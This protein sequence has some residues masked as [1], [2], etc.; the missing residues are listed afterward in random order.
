[1]AR[2]RLSLGLALLQLWFLAVVSEERYIEDTDRFPGWKGEL[3]GHNP[4][5]PK[6]LSQEKTGMT[7]GYGENGV[8]L[9]RGEVIPV[10]W[11][12]R[13]FLF[14]NFLNDTEC[15]HI[16]GKAKPQ[17]TKS[18]VVDNDTGKSVDSTVR[19]STGT[20]FGRGQDEII[21]AVEKRVSLVSHL[22]VENGEGMQVLHYKDGQ[23][24]EPH[25][26]FF[27]DKYNANPTNGGQRA[28][29]V[30]M[31][32]TTVDEGGETVFPN[33][34]TKVTGPEWSD[35]AK[36]GL[37]VKTRKGDALLFFSLNPDGT[38]DPSSL[39]GSCATTKGEK[40]SA[41]KWI[42]VQGFGLSA[43]MQRAKWGDCIDGDPRC[44]EWA[45]LGEC[46]NNPAYMLNSCR[47][48]CKACSESDQKASTQ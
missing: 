41:T 48:A 17:M 23:R 19:T 21:A 40:W 6:A 12:P 34:Q 18:T 13:A 4:G 14:K 35:C 36:N 8:E 11:K 7:V 28:A 45:A 9:W 42:H 39:H 44:D 1:M 29:T 24:Y 3:P 33:A 46:K 15:D 37:A 38:T 2:G 25:H 26:D 20:F 22:P 27:H 47:K 32:L 30:L 10:S 16:I 31:Y 43:E 5:Q